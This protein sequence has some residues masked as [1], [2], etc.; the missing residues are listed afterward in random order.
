MSRSSV[1]NIDCFPFLVS[2]VCS[3]TP[4]IVKSAW[5]IMF[6]NAKL[7]VYFAGTN[8]RERIIN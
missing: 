4:G 8:K 3:K 6:I 7:I 5:T 2:I 1:T